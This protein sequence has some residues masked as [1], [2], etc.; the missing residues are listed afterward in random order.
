MFASTQPSP[1]DEQFEVLC[2]IAQ[3]VSALIASGGSFAGLTDTQL[4]AT[5][6]PVSGQPV[7]PNFDLLG[8]SDSRS[9]PVGAKGWTATILT[10]TGTIGG[11]AVPAG[12][13]DGDSNTLLAAINVTTDGGSSAYVRWNT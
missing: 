6:V 7:T 9:I 2:K 4:R 1:N 3:A 10:G 8:A 11:L 5:P 12:F 13:S